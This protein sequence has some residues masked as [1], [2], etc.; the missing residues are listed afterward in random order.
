[1]IILDVCGVSLWECPTDKAKA[2]WVSQP[3]ERWRL[4]TNDEV[5]A[6]MSSSPAEILAAIA[7]KRAKPGKLAN[8][9]VTPPTSPQSSASWCQG[10]GCLCSEIAEC[11][12]SCKLSS[13]ISLTG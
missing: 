11:G 3:S 2:L 4:W 6:H 8:I 12:G 9:P 10:E 5:T 1:M 13:E 7:Q